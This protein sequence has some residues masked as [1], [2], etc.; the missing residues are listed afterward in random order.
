MITNEITEAVKAIADEIHPEAVFLFGD[1]AKDTE[2]ENSRVSLFVVLP[3]SVAD[4]SD[5][6]RKADKAVWDLPCRNIDILAGRVS[7]F[8]AR[9]KTEPL[10]RTVMKE[11]KPIYVKQ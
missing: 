1:Y 2:N 6:I 3:N 5:E 10:E 11:G 9:S 7:D 8:N 4:V